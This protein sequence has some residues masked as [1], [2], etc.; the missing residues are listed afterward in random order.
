[1]IIHMK[2]Y[3]STIK[4]VQRLKEEARIL[5]YQVD[6]YER[7]LEKIASHSDEAIAK[8]E[9]LYYWLAVCHRIAKDSLKLNR[10]KKDD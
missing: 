8:D 1:M 7:A 3:L 4:E 5:R 9:K 2:D 10:Q 6:N